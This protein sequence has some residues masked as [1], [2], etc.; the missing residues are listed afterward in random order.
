MNPGREGPVF[1]FRDFPIQFP[2]FRLD[3]AVM[4]QLKTF[5]A[6]AKKHHFWILCG[7]AVL[8]GLGMTYKAGTSLSKVYQRQKSTISGLKQKLM[9]LVTGDHPN[10]KWVASVDQKTVEF[11]HEVYDAWVQL[12]RQ[13]L[14]KVFVWPHDLTKEFIAAFKVG[15]APVPTTTMEYLREQYQTYV[16]AKALPRIAAMVDAQWVAHGD[17]AGAG[18]HSM[19]SRGIRSPDFQTDDTSDH[20]YKVVW[21]PTDQQRMYDAYNWQDPPSVLDVRYA[22]EELWVLEAVFGAIQRANNG[23]ASDE[24]NPAV[25]EIDQVS[26]GYDATNRFPLGEGEK[27][28]IQFTHPNPALAG[29]AGRGMGPQQPM[30]GAA[31]VPAFEPV[32]PERSKGGSSDSEG[33]AFPGGRRGRMFGRVG[34]NGMG[35]PMP[36]A[37]GGF[38]AAQDTAAGPTDPD[39]WLKDGRYVDSQ[40]KPLL[41]ADLQNSKTPEYKLMAF[42]LR[43][44]VDQSQFQKVIDELANSTMPLEVREVRVNPEQA[45]ADEDNSRGRERHRP[46]MDLGGAGGANGTVLHNA[47]LEV[48]GVAYLINPPDPTKIGLPATTTPSGATAAAETPAAGTPAAGTGIPAA[49]VG[50]PAAGAGTPAAGAGTPAAGAGTPAAGAGIPAANGAA[51]TAGVAAGTPTNATPGTPP[52]GGA[53]VP[54]T[55]GASTTGRRRG[56]E[57]SRSRSAIQAVMGKRRFAGE[58][59]E[60]SAFTIFSDRNRKP[61]GDA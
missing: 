57:R 40:G 41:A 47:V 23:P 28:I 9:P 26:I 45:G 51:P 30:G 61:K 6:S 31:T 42:K 1:P 54:A 37:P 15:A 32:R 24:F 16:T 53:G 17:K 27:R 48:D 33:S 7:L 12:Y 46:M 5:L 39:A 4:D 38:G 8:I 22:Q 11:R 59:R 25:R 29:M 43:L 10:D 34:P 56:S 55:T 13:Q 60:H 49:G 20:D 44:I 2:H 21:D 14:D 19:R 3:G 36:G 52:A 58:R 35:S 50:A 18:P